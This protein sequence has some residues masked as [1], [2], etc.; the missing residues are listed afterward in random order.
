LGISV[1]FDLRLP[2][3]DLKTV[4]TAVRL[5]TEI[6]A[7]QSPSKTATDETRITRQAKENCGG[8]TKSLEVWSSAFRRRIREPRKRGTPNPPAQSPA[9]KRGSR[10]NPKAGRQCGALQAVHEA[11]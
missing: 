8:R 6:P 3:Y 9:A 1:I 2:I 4:Q 5:A 11:F 7:I 10:R